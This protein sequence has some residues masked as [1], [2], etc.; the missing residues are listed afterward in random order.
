MN[1]NQARAQEAK[2]PT[3]KYVVLGLALYILTI[4]N[5]PSTLLT[6]DFLTYRIKAFK[7]YIYTYIY[8]HIYIYIFAIYI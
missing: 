4:I 5:P 6:N 1:E 7:L 2:L 8:I 3:G